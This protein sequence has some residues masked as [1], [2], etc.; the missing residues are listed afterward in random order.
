MLDI[1]RETGGRAY[2]NQNEIKDGVERAF[3]DEPAPTRLA[4]IQKTRSMTAS[5][6]TSR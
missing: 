3:Q 2:V 5:I 1:A 4:T 6:G